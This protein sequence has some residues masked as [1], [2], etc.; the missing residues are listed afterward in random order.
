MITI[1][2]PTPLTTSFIGLDIEERIVIS[3]RKVKQDHGITIKGVFFTD[4]ELLGVSARKNQIK[5][6]SCGD[7]LRSI[8]SQH[9]VY[10]NCGK[11]SIDGGEFEL[12]RDFTG[13]F[14]EL[15]KYY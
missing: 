6:L 4:T 8:Y 13:P 1:V 14:E 11:C 10:C 7:V 2:V 12:I 3:K 15:T 5:C 9:R